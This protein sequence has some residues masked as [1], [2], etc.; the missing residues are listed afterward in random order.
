MGGAAI[1]ALRFS[2]ASAATSIAG[3]ARLFD[4]PSF[5]ERGLQVENVL[6]TR[7]G[8]GL[9]PG[10]R[11]I[12]RFLGGLATSVKSIDLGAK[13]YQNLGS[14]TSRL[15]GY[16]DRLAK[17]SGGALGQEFVIRGADVKARVLELVTK[18]GTPQQLE[19][20]RK[21]VAYARQQGVLVKVILAQ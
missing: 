21:V 10:F 11:G 7:F 1:G 6:A 3:L 17:F 13:T 20:I 4:N 19:A 5:T 18:G 16:V 14:L 15:T 8:G 2:G 9:P 12:D